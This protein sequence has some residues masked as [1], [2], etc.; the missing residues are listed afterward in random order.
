MRFREDLLVKVIGAGFGRT[1]TMSTKVALEMLGFGPCY[2]MVEVFEHPEHIALWQAVADGNPDWRRI[3]D[4]YQAGVDWP[5]C[6]YYR[7]LMEVYP[8]A[9]VLLTVRDPE[10]WHASVMNTIG[11]NNNQETDDPQALAHRRMTEAIIWQNTFHGRVEDK[12]YAID[13]FERHNQAV[14]EYVPAERLLVFEAA[15]GWEPLCEFLG[16]PVPV[17][18]PFPRMNDT[19]SFRARFQVDATS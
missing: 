14:K 17:D 1:G 4:G 5:M 8:E 3:F 6:N 15:H 16:V 11:P 9:K 13:V 12:D 2:H 7:E 19:A 10:R 18:T